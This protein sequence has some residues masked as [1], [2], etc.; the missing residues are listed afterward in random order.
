MLPIAVSTVAEMS[1]KALSQ[2]PNVEMHVCIDYRLVH[3]AL[4]QGADIPRCRP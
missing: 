2:Q 1:V 4:E 3:H